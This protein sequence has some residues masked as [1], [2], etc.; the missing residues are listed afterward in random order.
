MPTKTVKKLHCIPLN[1]SDDRN[2]LT[3]FSHLQELPWSMLLDS[4]DSQ[5]SNAKFHIMVAQPLAFVQQSD[6]EITVTRH[7]EQPQHCD[8]QDSFEVLRQLQQEYPL[9]YTRDNQY[10]IPFAVGMLG[11]FSYDLGRNIEAIHSHSVTDY[12]SP[13]LAVGIYSWS[14]IQNTLTGELF[15]QYHPDYPHPDIDTVLHW[16]KAEKPR[17]SSKFSMTSAWQSNM[18]KQDYEQKIAKIHDY[19]HAGD[20]YQVNLA[21]RFSGD[22]QGCE[23]QAYLRLRKAN[24]APFSAFI[25]LDNSVIL[26]IS[27]ERFIAVSE[28]Q[29]Q[30]KPIKGTMPRGNTLKQDQANAETLR[31]SEKDRAENLMIVDLLR[32]DLSRT[33]APGTVNVPELFA[34]ESFPAVHHLVSTVEGKL[35]AEYDNLSLI[36]QAFPGGS[37]TGAPKIRAMQIIDELEPHRRNI[38]CGS[39]GY[40]DSSGNMDT[41]IC[42]RTVLCEGQHM[43]CWAGGGIVLDSDAKLEYQESLDKVSKIL[44]TLHSLDD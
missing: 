4:S 36:H 3:I 10:S 17:N 26:S 7:Q 28:R 40:L 8:V 25:R 29:V 33:C 44:P 43:Y 20:C 19:L 16:T 11:L 2:I 14:I 34:I 6:N 15:Y 12:D 23:W 32:N 31:T 9:E 24:N 13:D 42:I 5:H 30:T 18:S 37:I 22:Y 38:Y 39:I 35:A 1:I 41:S 21:Q 27:P